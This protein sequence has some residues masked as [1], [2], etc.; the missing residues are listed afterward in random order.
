LKAQLELKTAELD[1]ARERIAELKT[2]EHDS[3]IEK[4]RLLTLIE[5]QSRL[6]TPPAKAVAKRPAA[7]KEKEKTATAP[8]RPP[9]PPV[10][11]VSKKPVKKATRK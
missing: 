8:E 7:S 5:Q 10:K 4:N 9:K 3:G 2:R 6:L 1:M 11:S